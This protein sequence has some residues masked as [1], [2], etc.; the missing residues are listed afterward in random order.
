[1][2]DLTCK[3]NLNAICCVLYN[4]ELLHIVL[5]HSKDRGVL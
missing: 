4:G 1:M 3:D 2:V 5:S